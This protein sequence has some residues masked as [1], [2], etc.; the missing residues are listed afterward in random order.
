MMCIFLTVVINFPSKDDLAT[1]KINGKMH[2]SF[3]IT[4]HISLLAILNL[5]LS[6]PTKPQE[7]VKR[8]IKNLERKFKQQNFLLMAMHWIK[9]VENIFFY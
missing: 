5:K 1:N 8:A 6:I 9:E 2:N 4:L 3:L 7:D